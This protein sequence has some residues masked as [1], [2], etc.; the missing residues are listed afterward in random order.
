M[1]VCTVHNKAIVWNAKMDFI[2]TTSM[3]FV[4]INLTHNLVVLLDPTKNT[5]LE[6]VQNVKKAANNADNGTFVSLVNLA[7]I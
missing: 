7:S 2:W 5:P 1:D 3:S 6:S 4:M